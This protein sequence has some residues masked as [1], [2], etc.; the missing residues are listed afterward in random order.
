MTKIKGFKAAI[1]ALRGLD[2]KSQ[3]RIL[4][5]ILKKDPEMAGRLR[6][7]LV[8]FED[9]LKVNTQGMHR[10]FQEIPEPTWVL[11]LRGK[12]KEF[13]S[14][15]LKPFTKRKAEMI[16]LALD[17][18]GPQSAAKVEAAQKLILEKA[19]ELQQKGLLI[20]IS[21]DDPLV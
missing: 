1:E 20:F 9:L 4:S 5:E 10:L 11:A 15:L 19:L 17:H 2:E 21:G 8:L 18:L 13:V 12:N 16:Q 7:G 6:K 3:E 14:S